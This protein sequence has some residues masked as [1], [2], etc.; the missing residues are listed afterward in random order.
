MLAN[1]ENVKTLAFLID[2]KNH[3]QGL[4]EVTN[5]ETDYSDSAKLLH[6]SSIDCGGSVMIDGQRFDLILDD[7]ALIDGQPIPS[8]LDHNQ[9]VL[10]CGSCLIYKETV[11]RNGSRVAKDLTEDQIALIMRHIAVIVSGE[12]D[13]ENR[14][15]QPVLIVDEAK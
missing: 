4:Q 1:K 11:K 15:V 2:A 8:I 14:L 5:L 13:P 12:D 10:Y 3:T 6:T 9:N 7:L